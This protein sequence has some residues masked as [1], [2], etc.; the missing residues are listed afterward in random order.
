MKKTTLEHMVIGCVGKPHGVRGEVKIIPRT[1]DLRRFRKLR[2]VIIGETEY[3]V[4]FVKL[5]ADRAI[6]KLQGME[7]P[8]DLLP[9]RDLD[10]MVRREDAVKKKPGEYFIDEL[11]GLAVE[12]TNGEALGVVY[13]VLTTG[14]NDVYW[15]KEP[16][17]LLIPALKTIVTAVRLDEGKIVIR[18]PK[19][20]N[21]ED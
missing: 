2:Y 13:E 17:E 16:K 7:K 10:V 1:D 14:A 21:Y 4:E 19:E 15:I 3:D 20:W 11:K 8:E 12:D 5:Q 6:L 18:P 9:L